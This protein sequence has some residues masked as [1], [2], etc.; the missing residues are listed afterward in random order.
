MLADAAEAAGAVVIAGA[1]PHNVG[2]TRDGWW[3]EV[4]RGERIERFHARF[5]VDATGRTAWLARRLGSRRLRSDRMLAIVARIENADVADPDRRLLLEATSCGWWYC[6]RL[7][8]DVL[9][10][11]CL[12]GPAS[13]PQFVRDPL[14]F[15]RAELTGTEWIGKRLAGTPPPTTVKVVSAESSRLTA[16]GGADWLALG[17]AATTWDPLTSQ[18]MFKAVAESDSAAHAIRSA[19]AGDGAPLIEHVERITD[20]FRAHC[21]SRREYYA[22]VDRW[23]ESP[24][25]LPRGR[26]ARHLD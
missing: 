4:R 8:R 5:L 11:S 19:L 17:D 3:V 18:G 10:A 12:I 2:R 14:A 21:R 26:P 24:F 1:R 7:P 15:W 13:S 25:W 22:C 16:I 20:G 9:I 23:P 6:A